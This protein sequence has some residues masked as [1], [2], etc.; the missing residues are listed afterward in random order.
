MANGQFSGL[1]DDEVASCAQVLARVSRLLDGLKVLAAGE[2]AGRVLAG[3]FD[4]TGAASPGDYLCQS[5]LI[6]GAEAARRLTLA[7]AVLPGTGSITGG[8]VAREGR[9][10]VLP[11]PSRSGLVQ[12]PYD[13]ARL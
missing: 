8:R 5:L 9:H 10:S 1:S 3:R 12:G 2:L 13:D 7:H 11:P 6:G 4:A